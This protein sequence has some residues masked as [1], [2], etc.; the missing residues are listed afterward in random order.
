V[1]D[2]AGA[3]T[4]SRIGG[5]KIV[6][7]VPRPG[8]LATVHL[9]HCRFPDEAA[10]AATRSAGFT[11]IELAIV[12]AIIGILA[13]IAI[14]SYRNY[15]TRAR[16]SEGLALAQKL[17]HALALYYAVHGQLPPET[18][19]NWL[20]ALKALGFDANTTSGAGSGDAVQ[21]IWLYNNPDHP[22]IKIR[23][24]GA[25]IDDKLLYLEGHFN[26]GAVTWD[27]TSPSDG[28]IAA[29]YLPASCR[30]S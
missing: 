8:G 12:V 19:S 22:T 9:K 28:G 27:C 23:Y 13:A 11:L 7:I 6:I 14:P 25:P 3:L 16:V 4:G 15:V 26:G 24:R 17:K 2:F 30:P 18:G 5:K 20:G 29:R 1:L 21:R 10:C